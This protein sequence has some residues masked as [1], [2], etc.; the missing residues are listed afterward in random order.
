MRILVL[1]MLT[2]AAASSARA[3][4]YDPRYPVCMQ[5][6]VNFGGQH[7]ECAYFTMEQ[8]A[9]RASGLA[10]TCIVNPFYRGGRR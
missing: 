6:I 10:A 2:M 5:V 3:Q 9:Q 7:N 8:C 4:S 1:I